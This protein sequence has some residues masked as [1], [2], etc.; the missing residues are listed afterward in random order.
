M[1]LLYFS[2]LISVTPLAFADLYIDP[3]PMTPKN[4]ICKTKSDKCYLLTREITGIEMGDER[5]GR[6]KSAVGYGHATPGTFAANNLF[7]ELSNKGL[8]EE[9]RDAKV[10]CPGDKW[11][12]GR[13]NGMSIMAFVDRNDDE[14]KRVEQIAAEYNYFGYNS[15]VTVDGLK[16][17]AKVIH[18]DSDNSSSSSYRLS[19][20]SWL[21][22]LSLLFTFPY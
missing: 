19:V 22:S 11:L 8:C 3:P 21:L 16:P 5:S 17:A 14:I 2:L 18:K 4:I 12:V 13:V 7:V 6:G 15:T 20:V 10:E 1:R 9:V